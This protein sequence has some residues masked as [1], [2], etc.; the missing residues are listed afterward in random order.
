M[1]SGP[2][3]S[4]QRD[5]NPGHEVELRMEPPEK[6]GQRQETLAQPRRNGSS[7]EVLLFAGITPFQNGLFPKCPGCSRKVD[8]SNAACGHC[9]SSTDTAVLEVLVGLNFFDDHGGRVRCKTNLN[10]LCDLLAMAGG[11]VLDSILEDGT[12]ASLTSGM[13]DRRF[14]LYLSKVGPFH[15]L[16]SFIALLGRLKRKG[17]VSE[18][19]Y[20]YYYYCYHGAKHILNSVHHCT[21]TNLSKR[22]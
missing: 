18:D 6:E 16:E 10:G 3:Q 9:G 22:K 20:Y 19:Y 17:K 13:D 11:D 7:P 2:D 21:C 8:R 15:E 4:T 12:M 1:P 5:S 14:Q